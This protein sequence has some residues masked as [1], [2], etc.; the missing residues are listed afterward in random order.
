LKKTS[1]AVYDLANQQQVTIPL[2]EE[3]PTEI[4]RLIHAFNLL[5]ERLKAS[6]ETRRRLLAN[7]VHELGRPLGAFLS[8][9]QALRGGAVEQRDLREEL[10]EGMEGEVVVLQHL[11]N[12]LSH[13]D[14]GSQEVELN[15]QE[16]Y[17]ST[18]LPVIIRTWTEEAAQKGLALVQDIPGDLAPVFIDVDKMAQAIGNLISNA[19]RYT[20]AGGRITVA[21]NAVEGNLEL[22][23]QDTGPGIAEDEQERIFQPFYRGRSARRFSDG[24]GLGLTIAR[25]LVNAHGGGLSLES[26]LEAGSRF[27]IRIPLA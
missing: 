5:A 7:M 22:V 9:I 21:A 19:I 13:L 26:S 14:Q 16:T 24:M 1:Q 12:D 11:L 6:E 20:P 18:W 25:D 27:I 8:A 2:K 15:R 4:Q 23:V 10:L 17:P 3:G